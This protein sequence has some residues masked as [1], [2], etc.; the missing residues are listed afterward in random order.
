M[1]PKRKQ[2]YIILIIICIVV[3]AAIF[4]W[5]RIG[6]GGSSAVSTIPV[7][8]TPAL[9]AISATGVYTPPQVFPEIK[10]LDTAVLDSQEFK[11]LRPYAPI[12]LIPPTQI[13]PGDLGREDP[14][15]NF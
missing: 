11:L 5:G 3:S 8:V 14:F 9:P 4:L 1:D 7:A 12:Q 13:S 2:L 15:K 10:Q 6:G